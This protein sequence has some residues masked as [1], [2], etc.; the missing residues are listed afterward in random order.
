[1]SAEKPIASVTG[2]V[3]A[4]VLTVTGLTMRS[5]PPTR[6]HRE[7]VLLPSLAPSSTGPKGNGGPGSTSMDRQYVPLD[8]GG[9]QVAG[10]AR[11][12]APPGR[13]PSAPLTKKALPTRPPPQPEV[14]YIT[15]LKVW[16]PVE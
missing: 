5:G 7:S 10:C 6:M 1:M 11:A 12:C 16:M 9:G 13:G 15:R 4:T 3:Y 8:A 2:P 14:L